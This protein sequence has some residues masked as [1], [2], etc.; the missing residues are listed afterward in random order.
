MAKFKAGDKVVRT[1]FDN[2]GPGG[3]VRVGETYTVKRVSRR[4]WLELLEVPSLGDGNDPR[5][6]ELAS[7]FKVGDVVRLNEQSRRVNTHFPPGPFTV[8]EVGLWPRGVGVG[9]AAPDGEEYSANDYELVKVEP[10]RTAL[11]ELTAHRRNVLVKVLT[12]LDEDYAGA[13]MDEEGET[14]VPELTASLG[15][16]AA[17]MLDDD[18]TRA[19]DALVQLAADCLAWLEDA[20]SQPGEPNSL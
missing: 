15:E 8:T 7:P 19:H 4:G 3:V 6:F 9:L 2:D 18:R 16:V 11:Q 13:E 12:K 14:G 20:E 10:P 5:C 1:S 17:A